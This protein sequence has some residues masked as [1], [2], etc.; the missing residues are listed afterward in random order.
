MIDS[1]KF[2]I[3]TILAAENDLKCVIKTIAHGEQQSLELD[4]IRSL[5]GNHAA[6]ETETDFSAA[7]LDRG[8]WYEG[9]RSVEDLI[10]VQAHNH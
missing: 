4:H 1:K 5:R 3:C 10:S 7:D 6:S 2:K 9:K 8:W